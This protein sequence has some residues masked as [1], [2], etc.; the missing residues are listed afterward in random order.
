MGRAVFGILVGL[1]LTPAFA[2]AGSPAF[3]GTGAL[4]VAKRTLKDQSPIYTIAIA[5]P[6]TGDARIDA[7]ILTTVNNN[8]AGFKKEA[9]SSHDS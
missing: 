9:I 3:A 8:A 2:G 6:R 5:Y 7:D 1:L 4:P